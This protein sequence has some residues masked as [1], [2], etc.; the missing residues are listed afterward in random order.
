MS[1]SR[2]L[3]ELGPS[4]QH[5]LRAEVAA[6][7]VLAADAGLPWIDKKM[8]RDELIDGATVVQ[9]PKIQKLNRILGTLVSVAS[10]ALQH[11]RR[12]EEIIQKLLMTCAF[13]HS[14]AKCSNAM[15]R[16]ACDWLRCVDDETDTI[17]RLIVEWRQALALPLPFM[18]TGENYLMRMASQIE[19]GKGLAH[20]G[21][22]LRS[23]CR[24]LPFYYASSFDPMVLETNRVLLRKELFTLRDELPTQLVY[25]EEALRLARMGVY[26]PVLK[27]R[28]RIKMTAAPPPLVMID[29]KRWK[30]QLIVSFA[31]GLAALSKSR[32]AQDLGIT[33]AMMQFAGVASKVL[34]KRYFLIWLEF[35]RRRVEKRRAV[36]GMLLMADMMLMQ[37]Y[38]VKWVARR[39]H[40]RWLQRQYRAL[41]LGTRN[42]I[43]RRYMQKLFLKAATRRAERMIQR[44]IMLRAF[45]AL[46][47]RAVQNILRGQSKM[48]S[49]VEGGVKLAS[50]AHVAT[51]MR[52]V[53]WASR[54][55]L[56]AGP[57]KDYLR[58]VVASSHIIHVGQPTPTSTQH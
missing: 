25:C 33:S 38:Y 37:R 50:N 48:D 44:A 30:Q 5:N 54:M 17:V 47:C 6:F 56:L 18:V 21:A 8:Y 11:C 7:H 16:D 10:D 57:G 24:H 35:R 43:R 22:H 55:S 42:Q 4:L 26:Q 58:L 29:D 53:P 9:L 1:R 34:H 23:T 36:D 40:V 3:D 46:Q 12:R 51:G 27:F 14:H 19:P 52:E 15:H 28:H 31:N 41:E 49:V 45:R 20:I 32:P 39:N 2:Q 13:E